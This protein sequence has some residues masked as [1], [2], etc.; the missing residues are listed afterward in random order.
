LFLFLFCFLFFSGTC[1]FSGVGTGSDFKGGFWCP[2]NHNQIL[3]SPFC[4][5]WMISIWPTL[6]ENIIFFVFW[7]RVSLRSPGRPGTHFVDQAGLKLRNPPASASQVLGLKACN[8]TPG[9]I[10]V[11]Y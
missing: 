8:T 6:N 9:L 4:Y 10:F 2:H 11:F 5:W 1:W 7:D 3:Q